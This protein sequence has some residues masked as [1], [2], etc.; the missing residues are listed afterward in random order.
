MRL[1]VCEVYIEAWGPTNFDFP[2]GHAQGSVAV[3]RDPAR[4]VA[5]FLNI[6]GQNGEEHVVCNLSHLTDLDCSRILRGQFALRFEN[7][8]I[9]VQVSCP[10]P[11]A[12]N[13][14]RPIER[15]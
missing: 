2:L 5:L 11:F 12:W 15:I 14:L 13:N 8:Q 4:N 7:P 3:D 1:A 10:L 9:V 6:C